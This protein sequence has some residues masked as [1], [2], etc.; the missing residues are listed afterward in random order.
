MKDLFNEKHLESYLYQ[1]IPISKAIGIKALH[2]STDKV[3]LAT[4]FSNNINH[5]KTIFGGSLRCNISLL[6]F[7]TS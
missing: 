1:H 5:K 6:E 3:I 7:I 2:A 4:P